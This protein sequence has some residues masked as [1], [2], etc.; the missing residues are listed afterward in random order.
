MSDHPPRRSQALPSGQDPERKSGLNWL[1]RFI[2]ALGLGNGE[3]LKEQLERALKSEEEG[4]APFSAEERK[5]LLNILKFNELRVDDVMVPRANILAIEEEAPLDELLRLFAKAGHS[6]VPVY[7]G[8]LDE[9]LGMIHIKDVMRWMTQTAAS[10]AAGRHEAANGQ[11]RSLDLKCVDLSCSVKSLNLTREILF[12]PP[13]MPVLA[14]LR[15]MQTTH[16]HLALVIDEYGGTD[17]LASIED[18][19]EEVVGDIED[20]HDVEE[21]PLIVENA[22]GLIADARVSLKDMNAYLGADLSLQEVDDQTE[23]LGGLVLSILGRLPAPGER[24]RHPAGIEFEVMDVNQNRIGKLRLHLLSE[25]P[26]T[27]Q[28]EKHTAQS[29]HR[30]LPAA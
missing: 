30:P 3:G 13:S 9:P 25:E 18:L 2:S 27:A 14:L 29:R 10:A 22:S 16:I 5:M 23:S 11:A 20:E 1:H 26:A 17:G 15:R 21:E 6:R 4:E 7:R 8:S 19:I 24:I 12:V 28:A